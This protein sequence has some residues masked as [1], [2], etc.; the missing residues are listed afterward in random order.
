M[1]LEHS[2]IVVDAVVQLQLCNQ[3]TLAL[4]KAGKSLICTFEVSKLC[5][6]LGS[7]DGS[8]TST[9]IMKK[10]FFLGLLFFWSVS[11]LMA[12]HQRA[13]EITYRYISG[14]TYEVTIVTYSYAPSLADRFE[15]TINWGDNTNEPLVR[16][17]GPVN[18]NG[19]HI[20]ELVDVDIKRNLYVGVHTFPGAA[21]YKLWVEDPN[22]N[23]GIMNIPNS[24]D[25]P[26]YIESELS[27]NPFIGPNSSPELLLPPI[28]KGCVG[29]PYINNPAAYDPDGDSLSFTLVPCRGAGGVNIAG[30]KLPNKVFPQDSTATFKMDSTTGEILWKNPMHAGEYNI[31]FLV[32]EWRHGLKIG[33]VTRDMQITIIP[34]DNLPPVFSPMSK[35][36]C[37][38]AGD[39]IEFKVVATDP[40]H[41]NIKLTA[42]GAPFKVANPADFFS[43]TDSVGRNTG[44][45]SWITNCSNVRKN[46]YEAFFKAADNALPVSLVDLMTINIL[47][48]G[49]APKNLSATPL[50]NSIHLNWEKNKC[51]NVS[52]YEIYRRSGSYNFHPGHCELG[53]P[54]YTGYSL[55]K[56]LA[57]PDT[58]YFDSNGLSPGIDYCYMVVAKYPD[59]AESYASNES[60]A[61]LKKDLPVITNV[62]VEITGVANGKDYIAWSKPTEINPVQFPGPYKYLIYASEGITGTVYS[63]IDS[64]AS[65]N[66]TVYY[67]NLINTVGHGNRYRIDMYNDTPGQR[68]LMGSSKEASSSFLSIFPGDKKS[69]MRISSNVPWTVK[70]YYIFR[71]N[72]V[73][74]QFDSIGTSITPVYIDNKVVNGQQYCYKVKCVGTYGTDGFTDPLINWTQEVC[75]IPIDNE[76]PCPPVLTVETDCS[77]F[78]NVLSW[79]KKDSICSEDIVKFVVYYRPAQAPNL[80]PL[81]STA[82]FTYTHARLANIVGC[83]AIVA[84]DSAGNRSAISDSVCING[85]ACGVFSLPN[86]F[87][88]NA[89]EYN[90]Y[91]MPFPNAS[92]EKLDIRIFNRWGKTVYT[93][94]GKDLKWDGKIQGSNQPVA[95]G[96]YYYVCDVWE[97][98]LNGISKRTLKGSITVVR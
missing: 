94:S 18:V 6:I 75:I 23:Y 15:L 87:T 85:N 73:T 19:Q 5:L 62:S 79:V 47:V 33:Y 60:C 67:H 42:T 28:D 38:Q 61:K 52:G 55:I 93:Y 37:V 12:T 92:I 49:P 34:C 13:G 8:C 91:L 56:T 69:R 77:Q 82:S 44:I 76:K 90:D 50:G 17:N 27:I 57:T 81:D 26:L 95:D 80:V 1:I 41:N 45:F 4:L 20:G 98:N 22:R 58:T 32:E 53:V 66:D 43:P 89:D 97:I 68:N 46:T 21:T 63:L 88:P 7:G 83:Y 96:V 14:L 59:G 16:S 10:F 65:I 48:V 51:S 36:T 25:I 29:Q 11:Q 3:K 84:V 35:D 74:Q 70:H 40:N 54:A 86:V 71:K 78:Q 31:A 2:P 72:L 64:L 30:Y 24:V 39:T 9:E